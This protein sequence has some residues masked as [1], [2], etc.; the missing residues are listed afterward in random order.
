MKSP[1]SYGSIE[2]LSGNRRNPYMVRITTGW[3]LTDNGKTKQVRKIL[4]YYPS[5]RAA[6]IALA[7]YN[8]SPYNLDRTTATVSDVWTAAHA[9]LTASA[10]RIKKYDSAWEKYLKPIHNR[11]ISSVKAQELQDIINACPYGYSTQVVIKTVMKHIFTYAMQN[12]IIDK[13]YSSF[14]KVEREETQL[15]RQVYT[16]EE[17]AE[18][19][20][21]KDEPLYQF[22]LICLY[23]G[24]RLT[25]LRELPL[26]N[27]DME[28][29]TIRITKAKNKQS[30]RIIPIHEKVVDIVE[31]CIDNAHTN[32]LFDL[33]KHQYEYFVNNVL[34]HFPYDT[35]HTFATKANEL[36]IKKVIIQRIMGHKPDSILEQYYTHLTVEDLRPEL[37]RINY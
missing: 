27:I 25:E 19:W 35:R 29:L 33:S 10:D 22:T 6:V 11:P 32:T 37:N 4:G 26:E 14:V 21:H 12:D 15:Q 5:R 30:E 18:I 7:E 31:Q 16:P 36:D 20:K 13:D 3:E 28:N 23:E 17:I 8:K 34:H 1:N 2:K 9:Y 24:M